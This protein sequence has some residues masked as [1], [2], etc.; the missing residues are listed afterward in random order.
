MQE[1][2]SEGSTE[3]SVATHVAV[4]QVTDGVR[5]RAGEAVIG[6]VQGCELVRGSE[7]LAR[8]GASKLILGQAEGREGSEFRKYIWPQWPG[9][10]VGGEVEGFD[11]GETFSFIPEKTSFTKR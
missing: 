8:D 9:E 4:A 2:R 1:G 5:H 10:A 7:H 11:V 3:T 6:K